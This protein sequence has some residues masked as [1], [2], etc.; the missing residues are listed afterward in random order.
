MVKPDFIVHL[1]DK[2]SRYNDV[3]VN[4]L[5]D[6]LFMAYSTITSTDLI[7]NNQIFNQDWDTSCPFQT[8]LAIK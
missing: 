1:E 4:D 2:F 8:V 5:L 6:Y 7:K 3:K